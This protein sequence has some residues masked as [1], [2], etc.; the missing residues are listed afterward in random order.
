MT[1]YNLIEDK[2]IAQSLKEMVDEIME[3]K[4]QIVAL[5]REVEKLITK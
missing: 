4:A 1:T 3:L 2:M 5:Q